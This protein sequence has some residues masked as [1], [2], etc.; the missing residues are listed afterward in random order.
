MEYRFFGRFMVQFFFFFFK[1]SLFPLGSVPYGRDLSVLYV[2]NRVY[3][4]DKL[5][6]EGVCDKARYTNISVKNGMTHIKSL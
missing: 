3:I 2:S 5:M 1:S 4:L 6:W